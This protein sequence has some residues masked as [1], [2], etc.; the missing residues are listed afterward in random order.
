M[1]IIKM[2]ALRVAGCHQMSYKRKTKEGRK[3]KKADGKLNQPSV[4]AEQRELKSLTL[5]GA[6]N[7]PATDIYGNFQ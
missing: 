7:F 3:T 6:F 1:L 4:Y 2:M 5:F